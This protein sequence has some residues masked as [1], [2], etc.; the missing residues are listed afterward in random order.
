MFV[1]IFLISLQVR[2]IWISKKLFY[3]QTKPFALLMFKTLQLN[4]SNCDQ[5]LI[6]I[7]KILNIKRKSFS[8]F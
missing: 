5:G 2:E 7:V 6:S 8:D 3:K 4:I 1:N